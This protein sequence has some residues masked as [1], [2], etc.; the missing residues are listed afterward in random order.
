MNENL[1]AILDDRR[2]THGDFKDH[3]GITQR[4][5]NVLAVELG[6]GRSKLTD[7]QREV[8]EMIAHKIGRILAGN[9]NHADHWDDIAGYAT[10]VADQIRE[11]MNHISDTYIVLV[12]MAGDINHAKQLLRKMVY[13]PN[14]GLCVTIRAETFIYTGGEEEGFVLGFVNY[15][16]FRKSPEEIWSCARSIAD[17]LVRELCQWSAL[18]VA[19]NKTEWINLRP[20]DY[21]ASK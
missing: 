21:E 10:L 12:H 20:V 18:I 17:Q 13:P 1:K 7:S 4:L 19:N 15:P 16:R 9:P 6:C 5:K 14:E 11:K 3:A 8:L 2:K